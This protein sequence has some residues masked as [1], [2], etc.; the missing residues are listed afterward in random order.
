MRQS[1]PVLYNTVDISDLK[2]K[3]PEQL[4]R[5]YLSLEMTGMLTSESH[6]KYVMAFNRVLPQNYQPY[7]RTR[8]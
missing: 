7:K 8:Q 1:I 4:R 3:P 6:Q 5:E 2:D